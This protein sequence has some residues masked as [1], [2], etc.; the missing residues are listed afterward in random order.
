MLASKRFKKKTKQKNDACF[1]SIRLA[2]TAQP[3][4]KSNSILDSILTLQ[5]KQ[6]STKDIHHMETVQAGENA[7]KWG[8]GQRKT[9][10]VLLERGE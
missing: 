1:K 3:G 9:I 4:F 5:T 10:H 2:D 6:I 7:R 8:A